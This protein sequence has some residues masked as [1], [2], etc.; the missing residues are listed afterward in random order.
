M[1]HIFCHTNPILNLIPK[2]HA[3]KGLIIYDTT[4]GI[5]TLRKDVN[6]DHSNVLKKKW[7][8]NIL[9]FEGKGCVTKRDQIFLLTP[10]L[11]FFTKEPFKKKDFVPK[12][13]FGRFESFNHQK[14]SFFIVCGK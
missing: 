6:I 3:R 1:C 7:R 2:I 12:I 13:I 11:V 14:P 9:F 8:R 4:N 10:Y 5:T